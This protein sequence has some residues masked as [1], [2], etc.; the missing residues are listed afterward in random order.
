MCQKQN[1]HIVVSFR[2]IANCMAWLTS[3]WNMSNDVRSEGLGHGQGETAPN[4]DRPLQFGI[5]WT[6]I[7]NSLAIGRIAPIRQGHGFEAP[8]TF[9]IEGSRPFFAAAEIEYFV[10][11]RRGITHQFPVHKIVGRQL[12]R[13]LQRA[14]VIGH[15]LISVKK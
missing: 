5:Q 10:T 11:L 13:L 6:G 7:W 3:L 2:I 14:A 4:A 9:E 12:H 8:V 15:H 1:S